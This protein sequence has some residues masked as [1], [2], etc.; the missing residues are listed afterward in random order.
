MTKQSAAWSHAPVAVQASST[1]AAFCGRPRVG[2]M[3]S[4]SGTAQPPSCRVMG[5]GGHVLHGLVAQPA[6]VVG[7]GL[8]DGVQRPADVGDV[9]AE[10]YGTQRVEQI[11]QSVLDD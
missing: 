8:R 7:Q 5:D 2:T 3:M 1:A 4:R 10:P 9:V 11:S 6:R